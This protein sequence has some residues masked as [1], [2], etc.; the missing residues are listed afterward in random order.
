MCEMMALVPHPVALEV[1]LKAT[2]TQGHQGS[3]CSG[4]SVGTRVMNGVVYML[5]HM[6]HPC[7]LGAM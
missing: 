3:K 6:G 4:C 5:T 7:K 2:V 1:S